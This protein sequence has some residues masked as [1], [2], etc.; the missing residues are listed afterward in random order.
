MKTFLVIDCNSL[1]HRAYHALPPLKN[2]KGEIVNAVYG[3]F[4]IFI[5]SVK[6]INPDC[7]IATFDLP[8][9]TFR[10]KRYKEYKAKRPPTPGDLINQFPKVKEG[11][12]S[13]NVPVLEKRGFEADDIIGTVTNIISEGK[14][15]KSIILSG[16]KDN[17][18]LVSP[19]TEVCLLKKG[20]KDIGIY[21]TE[22][23]KR[24]YQGLSPH[25]LIDFKALKGDQSDNIPGV[26]GV[27]EKTAF[28]LIIRFNNLENI[29]EKINEDSSDII[30][31]VKLK[32][33]KNKDN[34]FMSKDLVTIRTNIKL[35]DFNLDD[36]RWEG[37]KRNGIIKFFKEIGFDTLIKRVNEEKPK[38]T[39][40]SLF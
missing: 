9:P 39:N 14:D 3:F 31:S 27:G 36:C 8:E 19:T 32:L 16:D 40:L 23:V 21:N 30:P 6:E 13:L 5:K 37:F 35:K 29:Y 11:L 2:K 4:S 15:Q 10:H 34:A 22:K 25:Q 1:V 33:C 26:S 18:Q 38:K 28:N 17:L 20:I 7:V 24:E 12:K